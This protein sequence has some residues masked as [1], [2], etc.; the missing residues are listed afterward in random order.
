M[1]RLRSTLFVHIKSGKTYL[2]LKRVNVV[3]NIIYFPPSSKLSFHNFN[4]DPDVLYPGQW[5]FL[6]GLRLLN[7]RR[8]SVVIVTVVI[9]TVGTVVIVTVVIV[10]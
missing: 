8:G 4:P 2:V 3:N 9:V 6:M 7:G 10:T 5:T 1:V